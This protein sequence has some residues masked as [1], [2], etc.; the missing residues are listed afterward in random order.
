[1]RALVGSDCR[2]DLVAK[3]QRRG[4]AVGFYFARYEQDHVRLAVVR[5]EG[6]LALAAYTGGAERPSYFMLLDWE[7]GQVAAIRDFRYVSYIAPTPNS[8]WP[9]GIVSVRSIVV[10]T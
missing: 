4:K 8:S 2:L 7:N 6:R 5:L 9:S 3:S 1:V 10:V